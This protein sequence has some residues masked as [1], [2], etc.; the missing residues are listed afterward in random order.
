MRQDCFREGPCLDEVRRRENP[1]SPMDV[2]RAMGCDGA[3]P[4]PRVPLPLHKPDEDE[5]LPRFRVRLKHGGS[6]R[7]RSATVR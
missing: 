4:R 6:P 5:N 1:I 2:R 7:S 3:L